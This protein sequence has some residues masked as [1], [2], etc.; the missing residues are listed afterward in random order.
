MSPNETTAVNADQIGAILANAE[1][2]KVLWG[3]QQRKRAATRCAEIAKEAIREAQE[4]LWELGD[5]GELG[6][7]ILDKLGYGEGG[8]NERALEVLRTIEGRI[9]EEF[10]L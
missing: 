5:S 3:E 4:I 9:R 10:W 2:S 8:P 7:Y 6:D 1:A